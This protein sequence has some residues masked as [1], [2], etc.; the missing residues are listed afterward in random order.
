MARAAVTRPEPELRYA[1]EETGKD[2][3]AAV[4]HGFHGDYSDDHWD[5]DQRW[6]EWE[7]AFGYAVGDRWIATCAANSRVMTVPGGTVPTAGVTLVTVSSSYR[8]RGL[9]RSMMQHQLEDVARRR[10]PVAL[11]WASEAM[12]YGRFGYG[13]CAPRITISGHTR[14][15]TFLD[16]VDLGNGWVEGVTTEEYRAAASDLHT[17]LLPDRPGALNR[18][19]VWWE[20]VLYDPKDFREGASAYRFLLHLSAN[21]EVDGYAQYRVKGDWNHQGPVGELRIHELDAANGP[22]RAALWRHLLDLDLVRTYKFYDAP[23]D[24]PLRYLVADQRAVRTEVSD[25][26]YARIVLVAAALEAR[27]YAADLDLVVGLTDSM[28]PANSGAFRIEAAAGGHARVSKSRRKPDLEMNIR[29]LGAVYLGGVSLRT[30]QGAGL[31]QARYPEA[32]GAMT[33]AFE[34][35]R[36]PFCPDHF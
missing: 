13:S 10:E 35:D 16:S 32:V 31:V 28:L 3:F 1:D 24:E 15:T 5:H 27:R 7:R 23:A 25:G 4:M 29:E 11:L 19:D 22:A 2:Y 36:L 6:M 9:L 26:T 18:N 12:I 21:G 30:L 20:R 14:A 33:M 8:R 34:W 17:R